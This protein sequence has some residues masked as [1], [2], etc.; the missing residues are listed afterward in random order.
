MESRQD[1]RTDGSRG[2]RGACTRWASISGVSYV[3]VRVKILVE[4]DCEGEPLQPGGALCSSQRQCG[5][6]VLNDLSRHSDALLIVNQQYLT[7][8][9][10]LPWENQSALPA[11]SCCSQAGRGWQWPHR[12]YPHRCLLQS[13]S[14]PVEPF[15]GSFFLHWA[16]IPTGKHQNTSLEL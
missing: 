9:P 5:C 7:V 15:T 4:L 10:G 13:Y 8:F 1:T 6:E 14:F 16:C 12:A 11:G 3:V 2:F